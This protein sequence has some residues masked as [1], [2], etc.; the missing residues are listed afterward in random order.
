MKMS[1]AS[2]TIMPTEM[3][4]VGS[5][6]NAC[7]NPNFTGLPLSWRH[8]YQAR[9]TVSTAHSRHS[10]LRRLR[11][12]CVTTSTRSSRMT[13]SLERSAVAVAFSWRI[14]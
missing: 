9:G 2:I 5:S 7:G 6:V 4:S 13:V 3:N 12:R 11:S 8:Q 1:A 14:S 10:R